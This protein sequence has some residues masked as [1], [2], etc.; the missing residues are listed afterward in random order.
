VINKFNSVLATTDYLFKSNAD[1]DDKMLLRDFTTLFDLYLS[2]I[3]N[4]I[5]N[6]YVD[7]LNESVNLLENY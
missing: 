7:K 2:N 4:D 1:I 6:I 5:I 3:E